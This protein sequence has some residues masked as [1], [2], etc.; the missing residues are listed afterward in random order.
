[1]AEP[2]RDYP[3]Y[4]VG[5]SKAHTFIEGADPRPI[6]HYE[7]SKDGM[8]IYDPV[9]G[10]CFIGDR[11]GDEILL[12]LVNNPLVR[13]TMSIEQLTLDKHTETIPG[14][15]E[16]S[17]W[18]HI[19]GSVVFVRQMTEDMQLSDR[20]KMILQLRTF[21]SDLGHTA[22]SHLGDWMFQSEGQ[23]EN[24]HDQELMRLLEISG[25]NNVLRQHSIDPADVVFPDVQDWIERPQPDLCVD[26]VDFGA[27]E[28]QRWAEFSVPLHY[29]I[30]RE[31]FTIDESGNMVMKNL[32]LAREFAT[33]YLL[34]PTEHWN[35][36][37]H[38]LQLFLQEQLVKRVL[39][40]DEAGLFASY[41]DPPTEYYPRDYL[42][43]FDFDIT[44]EQLRSWDPFLSVTR[45]VME[46][47]GK[48]SRRNFVF[49]RKQQLQ[50]LFSQFGD[51]PDFPTPLKKYGDYGSL[52]MLPP[53]VEMAQVQ[54]EEDIPDF[55]Q[56]PDTID[57]F[58]PSLKPRYIDPLYVNSRGG[59]SRLS[60]ADHKF[61]KL[62][63]QQ[64]EISARS[65]V[66][67]IHLNPETRAIIA[68]GVSENKIMWQEAL[69]RPRMSPE[70]F[71]AMLGEVAMVGANHRLVTLD[72]LD[73]EAI[74]R[75]RAY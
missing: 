50:H 11:P 69:E 1:M 46:D 20:E 55:Q 66:A 16:F 12:D 31:A 57:V 17:R 10:R 62:L 40:S 33:A 21:V 2:E 39:T 75:F 23:V 24:Q 60:E 36:P 58:L 74:G 6:A 49:Q 72:A 68:D 67:R 63:K 51:N 73:S 65:Y 27:R 54:S 3:L 53:Y 18:E 38:R 4:V 34:L 41:M 32:K 28:I 45:L 47:I 7:F 9:W 37:I 25:I 15:A 43:S 64:K 44:W 35:E 30:Q 13:R 26:R 42:Y 14:A 48:S 5:D 61:R 8:M 56:R 22:Y 70:R 71:V 59:Y 19:W 52:P 29:A